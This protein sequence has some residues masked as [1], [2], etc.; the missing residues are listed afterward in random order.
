VCFEER[1]QSLQSRNFRRPGRRDR[2]ALRLPTTRA[3]VNG[4]DVPEG[5]VAVVGARSDSPARHLRDGVVDGRPGALPFVVRRVQIPY[6]LPYRTVRDRPLGSGFVL[7]VQEVEVARE[8]GLLGVRRVLDSTPL[9]D[10]VATMD[11]VSLVR[12]AIRG[13]L[14]AADEQ[15]DGL[16]SVLRRDDDYRSGGKPAC[17]W[18][19]A[20][21]RLALVD[22]LAHDGQARRSLC[23]ATLR[24]PPAPCSQRSTQAGCRPVSGYSSTARRAVWAR[25]RCRSPAPS[26]AISV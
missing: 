11:T 15:E 21:A 19:D 18:E 9:Y 26:P 17:D 1:R 13:V 24:T 14:A 7:R 25:T 3:E 8:A 4:G 20:E 16:R 6:R 10:A 5:T 2:V 22:A 12:S 23:T